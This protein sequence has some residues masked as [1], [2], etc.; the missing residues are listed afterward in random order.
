MISFFDK[1]PERVW[2]VWYMLLALAVVEGIFWAD[3]RPDYVL[4][5]TAL[6][7]IIYGIYE[8]QR[9]PSAT[10]R[11][12]VLAIALAFVWGHFWG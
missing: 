11:K 5:F 12:F 7:L 9:R 3:G 2:S 8:S 4:P 1:I 6:C 10:I